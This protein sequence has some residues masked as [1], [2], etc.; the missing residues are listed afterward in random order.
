MSS[1]S[2]IIVANAPVSYGA[3]EVTIGFDPNVPDGDDILDQVSA[4]GY[5]GIDLGPVGY[6]GTPR[7]RLEARQAGD[8]SR[9]CVPGTALRGPEM[10]EKTLPEL[11]A[12][13]DIFDV[14]KP[15]GL[16]PDPRPTL[17][18]LGVGDGADFRRNN[19]GS[20]ARNPASG[21]AEEQWAEFARGMAVVVDRCRSRGYKPVF[22]NETGTFV[23]APEE[24]GRMLEVSEIG[25]C[26]D[27]GHFLVGGGDPVEY[28]KKWANRIDHVHIKTAD[29]PR[30]QEIV[31]EGLPTNA[32][33]EREVFPKLGEGALDVDAFLAALREIDYAGWLVVEQDIFP[34]TAERFA[35]AA[36]DQR[37]NREFLR[38][39][40]L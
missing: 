19:P 27:A 20:G 28:V 35:Q 14:I 3:F 21:Y 2:G 30:F 38:E 32:I 36:A 17:A 4:A 12:M 7:A 37:V 5:A 33:W 18:D 6:L 29:L 24:V 9:R 10:L 31:E 23:E 15:L 1:N 11:D 26:M 40:G 22:H 25:L 8:R 16:G 39:R 13:L 34:T